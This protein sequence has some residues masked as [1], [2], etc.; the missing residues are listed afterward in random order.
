MQATQDH[1]LSVRYTLGLVVLVQSL[2]QTC[3][4]HRRLDLNATK[5][6]P[7]AS[8]GTTWLDDDDWRWDND[9]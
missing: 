8:E 3:L 2:D 6:R 4:I 5:S 1:V 7:K 9:N